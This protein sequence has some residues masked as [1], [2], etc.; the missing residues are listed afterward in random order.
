VR[1]DPDDVI[2]V[3]TA[4]SPEI[5]ALEHTLGMRLGEAWGW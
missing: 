3:R 4:L 1:P 2:T 5:E